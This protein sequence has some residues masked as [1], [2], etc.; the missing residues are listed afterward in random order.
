[1]I[2]NLNAKNDIS[3]IVVMQFNFDSS[4]HFKDLSTDSVQYNSQ[5]LPFHMMQ[6]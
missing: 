2:L 5:A 6:N 3:S 4:F 1:M